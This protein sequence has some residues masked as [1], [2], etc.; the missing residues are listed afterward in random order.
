VDIETA[1]F[2][3]GKK[4]EPVPSHEDKDATTVFLL[5]DEPA[6]QAVLR[7]AL[8]RRGLSVFGSTQ[9]SEVARR[10]FESTAQRACLVADLNMPGI[11]GED[12]CR[13][14]RRYRPDLLLILYTGADQAEAKAAAERLGSVPFVLKREGSA[15]LCDVLASLLG[16]DEA[17]ESP[18]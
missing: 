10:V 18:A 9:W 17:E 15:R 8:E 5:D 3:V 7:H 2:R 12:F 14:V 11:R 6:V 16:D 13:I 4:T 1:G